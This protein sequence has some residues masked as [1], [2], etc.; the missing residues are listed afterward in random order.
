[1]GG[2]S[3]SCLLLIVAEA[4]A[5]PLKAN[6]DTKLQSASPATSPIR[7]YT[8][9]DKDAHGSSNAERPCTAVSYAFFFSC[10]S[11]LT[12]RPRATVRRRNPGREGR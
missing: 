6:N 12:S 8:H 7:H 9:H 11:K 5:A 1:M 10:E 4:N 3:S 2:I